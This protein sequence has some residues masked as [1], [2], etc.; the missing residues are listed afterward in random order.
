MTAL[1]PVLAALLPVLALTLLFMPARQPQ[2]GVWLSNAAFHCAFWLMTGSDT[3]S[4]PE[5]HTGWR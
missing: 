1:L 4:G 5:Q 3:L 2:C